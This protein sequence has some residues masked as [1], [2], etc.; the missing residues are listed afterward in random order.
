MGFVVLS[1]NSGDNNCRRNNMPLTHFTSRF[2]IM[3]N[4]PNSILQFVCN[5]IKCILHDDQHF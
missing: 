2:D 3:L 5:R 4:L 1:R